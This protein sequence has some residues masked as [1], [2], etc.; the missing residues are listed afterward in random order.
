MLTAQCVRLRFNISESGIFYLMFEIISVSCVGDSPQFRVQHSKSSFNQSAAVLATLPS[1]F[2]ECKS[3]MQI[4][5]L[6]MKGWARLRNKELK[7]EPARSAW[8]HDAPMDV[9]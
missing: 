9:N 5:S 4:P 8:Y 7:S 1:Q 6:I 3:L 2:D